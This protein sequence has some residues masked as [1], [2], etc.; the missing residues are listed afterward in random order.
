MKLN[1]RGFLQ[2]LA[3]GVAAGPKIFRPNSSTDILR[4]P[5]EKSFAVAK[6]SF[7]HQMRETVCISGPVDPAMAELFFPPKHQNCRSGSTG[8]R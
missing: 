6:F 1:R 3:A 2:I 4:V 5:T 7:T 8:P